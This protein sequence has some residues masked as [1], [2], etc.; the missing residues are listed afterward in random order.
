VLLPECPH[1]FG[2]ELLLL[3]ILLVQFDPRLDS[4]V[5]KNKN[6]NILTT[7]TKTKIIKNLVDKKGK[8]TNLP[9]IVMKQT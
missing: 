3:V 7:K 8:R 6:E 5:G 1:D 2:S 4:P 9:G